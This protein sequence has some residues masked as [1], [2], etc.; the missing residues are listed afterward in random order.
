[1][2]ENLKA[3]GATRFFNITLVGL[4]IYHYLC[5]YHYTDIKAQYI[6]LINHIMIFTNRSITTADALSILGPRFRDY[7]MRL[8]LTRKEVA[9]AS[10]IG[11]TTLFRLETGKMTD[12]SFSTIMRLLRSIGQH[13]NWENLLPELP[14]SPYL[15]NDKNKKAQRIRH[16]KNELH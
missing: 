11:M 3:V 2:K 15:Y 8:K 10:G 13:D 6:Y 14:E 4:N 9:E 7:R 1:M 5:K 12:I 16:S